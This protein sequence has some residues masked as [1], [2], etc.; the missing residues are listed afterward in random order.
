MP[1]ASSSV[2]DQ[3]TVTAP[4]AS[5]AVPV[6]SASS[7]LLTESRIARDAGDYAAAAA[8]I[9]RALRIEPNNAVLWLEYAEL[10]MA[11]GDL[12]QA[13]ML[14]RKTASLAGDDRSIQEASGRLLAEISSR[15][16]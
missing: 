13:E 4:A 8:S 6:P 3:S 1:R 10:R 14:A 15:A 16:R 5:A 2:P 7:A 9:E 11:E 12:E